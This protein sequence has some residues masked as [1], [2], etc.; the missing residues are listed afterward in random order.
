MLEVIVLDI[1]RPPFF[2]FRLPFFLFFPLKYC[3]KAVRHCFPSLLS[4][5]FSASVVGDRFRVM[6]VSFFIFLSKFTSNIKI[7]LL[8]QCNLGNV[9]NVLD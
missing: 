9:S 5:S 8:F 1:F 4:S 2:L 7:C 6:L 3:L